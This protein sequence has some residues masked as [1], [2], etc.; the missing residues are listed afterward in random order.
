MLVL[1]MVVHVGLPT[2]HQLQPKQL[3]HRALQR[4]QLLQKA[5]MVRGQRLGRHLGRPLLR[6]ML[7][8][9]LSSEPKARTHCM[10]WLA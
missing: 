2:Q 1:L 9:W 5:M 4:E 10:M 3:R 6:L 7:P 8:I